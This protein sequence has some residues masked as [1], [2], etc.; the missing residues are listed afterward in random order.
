M[1]MCEYDVSLKDSNSF[2][3]LSSTVIKLFLP[4]NKNVLS[5]TEL[6]FLYSF[7]L[8][9]ALLTTLKLESNFLSAVEDSN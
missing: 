8:M 3:S 5:H 2:R 9:V 4:S 1:S 6:T 7:W